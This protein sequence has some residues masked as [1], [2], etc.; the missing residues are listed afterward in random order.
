MWPPDGPIGHDLEDSMEL[1]F[2][3]NHDSAL[4]MPGTHE[5]QIYEYGLMLNRA[6][7]PLFHRN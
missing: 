3:I 7:S 5:A 4:C 1:D 2:L 6:N